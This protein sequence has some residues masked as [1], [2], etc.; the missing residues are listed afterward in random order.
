MIM[1]LPDIGETTLLRGNPPVGSCTVCTGSMEIGQKS[2][3]GR[4][5]TFGNGLSYEENR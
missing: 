2:H 3:F 4:A 5:K 1:A